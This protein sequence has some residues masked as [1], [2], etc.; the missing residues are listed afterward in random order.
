MIA[1]LQHRDETGSALVVALAFVSLFGVFIA[2]ILA[3]VSTNMKLTG[4]TRAR[5]DRLFAA[6]AGLEWG[7]QQARTQNSACANVPAGDQTLTTTL[8]V[9][10]RAVTVTC[11]ALAGAVASPASQNWSVI[12]TNGVI[13]GPGTTPEIAG[14]DVWAAGPS[15][16]NTIVTSGADVIRSLPSCAA[17]SLTGLTVG[18][19]DMAS[20][21]S[22]AAPDVPH[23]LPAVP[24]L[25]MPA[26]Q[27]TCVNPD[28]GRIWHP[29]KY[30]AALIDPGVYNYLESG[31]Y[32]FEDVNLVWYDIEIFG[33]TPPPGETA[34]VSATCAW[35]D[36]TAGPAS[37][38]SG[39]G[40]TIILGG[41]SSIRVSGPNSKFE[42]FT[43]V[44]A[45]PDGTAGIS[46][47]T[48]PT[49]G[50]GYKAW[51]APIAPP[52]ALSLNGRPAVHGLV[53]ARNAPVTITTNV[54]APLL[55][56]VVAS[57]LTILPGAGPKAV[58]ASG[59]RTLLLT[60]TAAPAA[61][62]EIAAVQSTVVKIANDPT[63]TASVR[64]W[65]AQ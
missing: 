47:I 15:P 13:A 35:D 57:T 53:H 29:G 50:A 51:T 46:I 10:G 41:T 40:V 22:A 27:R 48:V 32:Y 14:G 5:A 12:A 49:T 8:Q 65:R 2:A 36:T 24:P 6:D 30:T 33:G 44:P 60:S 38:A 4:T 26:T 1:R 45:T 64:S 20:C 31:V 56:G 63:R 23:A 19:P 59:R 54:T 37:R 16:V 18:V 39:A 52:L 3:Q 11:K 43:R 34:I 55:G 61:A 17:F 25:R 42:L 28:D 21:T 62:G 7:I 9:N 58:E